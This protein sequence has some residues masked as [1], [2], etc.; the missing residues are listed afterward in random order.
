MRWS[1]ELLK[2]GPATVMLAY[3]FLQTLAPARGGRYNWFDVLY[4]RLSLVELVEELVLHRLDDVVHLDDMENAVA[5]MVLESPLTGDDVLTIA[6]TA[7]LF[8]HLQNFRS[9]MSHYSPDGLIDDDES[10]WN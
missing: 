10:G 1:A 6:I 8:Q 3:S 5:E 2:E 7:V 9:T 4:I